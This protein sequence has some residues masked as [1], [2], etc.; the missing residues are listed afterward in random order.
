MCVWEGEGVHVCV[1]GRGYVCV[2]E[3]GVQV[4]KCTNQDIDSNALCFLSIK[5]WELLGLV[6]G[7]VMMEQLY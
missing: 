5:V 2:W 3:G 6:V 1:G 7:L 4:R